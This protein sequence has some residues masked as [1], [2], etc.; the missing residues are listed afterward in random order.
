[1]K[2]YRRLLA[3]IFFIMMYLIVHGLVIGSSTSSEISMSRVF[4]DTT[5]SPGES[6]TI[7][8]SVYFGNILNPAHGVYITDNIPNP[9]LGSL[10][11]VSVEVGGVDITSQITLE[12]D[13][14]GAIYNGTSPIRWI[15]ETPPWFLENIPINANDSIVVKYTISVPDSATDSTVYHFP[16]AGWV[17]T[18]D[19][20]GTNTYEFGYEDFPNPSLIVIIMPPVTRNDIDR[21]IKYFKEGISNKAKILSLLSRYMQGK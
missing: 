2:I 20:L 18:I 6:A 16:N 7:T 3:P 9:L 21:E 12:Q 8:L 10:T 13:S 1:M 19:S 17:S 4:S 11:T 14:S 15:L 5:L